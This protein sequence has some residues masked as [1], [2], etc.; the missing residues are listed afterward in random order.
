[1]PGAEVTVAAELHI[2]YGGLIDQAVVAAAV[3]EAGAPP[4]LATAS[5]AGLSLWRGGAGDA[6][7]L[8]SVACEQP[9]PGV[10][11]LSAMPAGPQQAMAMSAGAVL[12]WDVAANSLHAWLACPAD[13]GELAAAVCTGGGQLLAAQ[14]GGALW[15]CDPRSNASAVCLA[16][17]PCVSLRALAADG[18]LVYALLG[19]DSTLSVLDGRAPAMPLATHSLRPGPPPDMRTDHFPEQLPQPALTLH[20]DPWSR[21]RVSVSG[22]DAAV[23]IYDVA[24]GAAALDPLFVHQVFFNRKQ[25]FTVCL[26][27][28]FN[29]FFFFF[30][31]LRGQEHAEDA[32][33]VLTHMWHPTR[34]HTL[35]SADSSGFVHMWT[36]TVLQGAG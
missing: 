14:A 35:L 22:R 15:S 5:E 23:R 29:N 18:H 28:L 26:R 34:P 13:G 25:T 24:S 1:M 33:C 21:G 30:F 9:V 32:A 36:P 20:A 27:F 19:D 16:R 17:I 11:V 8:M 3:L 10:R 4:V 6:A 7:D 2:A 12:G 31:F